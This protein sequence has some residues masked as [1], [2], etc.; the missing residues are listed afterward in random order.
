[1]ARGRTGKGKVDLSDTSMN[2]DPTPFLFP[3]PSSLRFCASK[4]A[5]SDLRRAIWQQSLWR[6]KERKCPHHKEISVTVPPTIS[7]I[8]LSTGVAALAERFN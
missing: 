3:P 4:M 7:H 1:M 2:Q 5:D 6:E 8:A